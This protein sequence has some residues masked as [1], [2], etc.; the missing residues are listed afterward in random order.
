MNKVGHYIEMIGN[1]FLL[2]S[3]ATILY[4]IVHYLINGYYKGASL[5]FYTSKIGF[6][7]FNLNTGLVNLNTGLVGLDKII[8]YI[9]DSLACIPLMLIGAVFVIIG[10][11]KQMKK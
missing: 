3:F 7:L 6:Y 9:L 8:N 4:E 1:F 2:L 5:N 10:E 11:L